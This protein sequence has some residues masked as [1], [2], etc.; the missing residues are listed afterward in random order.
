MASRHQSAGSLFLAEF[1][2]KFPVLWLETGSH[3]TAS[4]T[5]QSPQ[6]KLSRVDVKWGVSAGISGHSLPGFWSP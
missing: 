6:T 1:L 2:K 3:M 4:T 5:I